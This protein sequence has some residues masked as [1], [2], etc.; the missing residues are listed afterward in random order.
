LN[1][2]QEQFE[3]IEDEDDSAGLKDGFDWY[4]SPSDKSKYEEIYTA[5]R[6][7]RGEIACMFFLLTWS[8]FLLVI[9]R[10][11][12]CRKLLQVGR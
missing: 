4:M 11:H 12:P 9:I 8:S 5:N 10:F 2:R 1:N 6:N 3:R 7:H